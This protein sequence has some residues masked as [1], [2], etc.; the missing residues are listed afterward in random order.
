MKRQDHA[1][2]E[3]WS[4]PLLGERHRYRTLPRRPRRGYPNSVLLAL[5]LILGALAAMGWQLWLFLQ[6][7]LAPPPRPEF[8]QV[9]PP[10]LAL[11]P[12][13]GAASPTPTPVVSG[14]PD[15]QRKVIEPLGLILRQ[16]PGVDGTRIG[17]I[18]LGETVTLLEE[19]ADGQWERVRREL[20]AQEGWVKAG[21]LGSLDAPLPTPLPTPT[22]TATPAATPTPASSPSPSPPTPGAV[23]P[24][25]AASPAS[26]PRP[27]APVPIAVGG[28]G[29]V[30]EPLG[31]ILRDNPAGSQIGG[32]PVGEAVTVLGTSADG[33]WQRVRRGSGE[34]GWIRAGNL[35]Q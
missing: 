26:T 9:T 33:Q 8:S 6:P 1:D 17:G 23:S 12:T 5:G 16:E 22:P 27:P 15:R 24:E 11:R 34:E 25:L 21:N 18:V 14:D 20:N 10:P 28:R 30:V 32:I 3:R 29:T 7:M 2:Q 4:E 13:P 31:L 19:S 35:G